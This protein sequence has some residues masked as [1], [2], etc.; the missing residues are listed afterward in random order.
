ML[1]HEKVTMKMDLS[2]FNDLRATIGRNPAI[3]AIRRGMGCLGS[4]AHPKK[5][6]KTQFDS[7]RTKKKNTINTYNFK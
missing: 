7:N 5:I 3:G 6:L 1:L 2:R 4:L